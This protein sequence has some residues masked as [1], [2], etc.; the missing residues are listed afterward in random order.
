MLETSLVH[1]SQEPRSGEPPYPAL[2][3]LHGVGSN[4]DDMMSLAPFVDPRL[5]VVAAR[6]P[7]ARRYGG[8]SWF[9]YENEGPGLGGPSIEDSLHALGRFLGEAVDRYSLDPT[10]LFLGGFSQGA[11]MTGAFTLLEPDRVAGAVMASG[12][13]PPDA[14]PPRYRGQEL[15]GTPIFQAHGRYDNVVPVHFAHQ[16]RDYLAATAAKLT[17]REY[18]MGHQVTAEELSDLS[19]WMHEQLE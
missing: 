8:Y 18:P 12:F 16:T 13:L 9:D 4:E 15:S 17:Y 5:Y 19:A 11:A 1:R 6:A 10:R 2:V 7:F 14:S 3:L